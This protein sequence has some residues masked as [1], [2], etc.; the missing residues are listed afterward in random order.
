MAQEELLVE[1][2]ADVSEAVDGFDEVTE[3]AEGTEE[4]FFDLDPA[5]AAASGGILAVGAASQEVLDQ[6]A[7]WREGLGRTAETMG[8]NRD[9][10]EELASSISNVTFPMDDAVGTMD[11]LARQGVE[12]KDEMEEVALRMDQMA[13]ATGSSAESI[14]S[15]VAPTLKAL[16][17]D[18]T[19]VE[20]HMDT[21]TFV[22]RNTGLSIEG[23]GK[24]V[25]RLAP[26]LQKMGAG[27]DDVGAI[28]AA[29]E[30]KGITGRGALRELNQA[31]RNAEGDFGKMK[32]E[33]G[34]TNEEVATQRDRLEDAEGVTVSHADAAN[35]ALTAQDQLG[36]ALDEV[37]LAAGS[38]MG[39]VSA[40]APAMEAMGSA[41]L[42]MS[43]VNFSAVVPGLLAAT[44]AALPWILA[45]GAIV[46]LGVLLFKKWDTVTS[47]LQTAWT[48]TVDLFT[49]L[50]GDLVRVL[51]DA[52]QDVKEA[53]SRVWAKVKG[54][55]KDNIAG[56]VAFLVG[57][58]I[59]F[60]VVKNWGK[61]R[62]AAG[63]A[64]ASIRDLI[65]GPV[66]TFTG[67]VTG[68]SN[69]VKGTLVAA[70]AF[71]KDLTREAWRGIRNFIVNPVTDA[72]DS[73][74]GILGSVQ[75][76]LGQVWDAI[77]EKTGE[78]WAGVKANILDPLKELASDVFGF[79]QDIV[80][81]F[82][83]GLK[84]KWDSFTGW[85]EDK[86]GAVI[87][88]VTD[89]FEF[90]SPSRVFE[91]FGG[92]VV[93]GFQEGAADFPEA[94]PTGAVERALTRP[95]GGP[96]SSSKRGGGGDTFLIEEVTLQDVRDPDD[97]LRRL[98]KR[99]RESSNRRFRKDGTP[100]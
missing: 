82:W 79:G 43:T 5:G 7:D 34:L 38:A 50:T 89:I 12:T 85:I 13:D 96:T 94:V 83:D 73:V 45:I 31:A 61:I 3:S 65:M 51:G 36:Q 19:D 90:G 22:A 81:G 37:K 53:T 56:I 23:F 59:L 69:K 4:A 11:V 66:A 80:Q 76:K 26:D 48:A 16:G 39:P 30:E 93:E 6:T 21:F 88:T 62:A 75:S 78:V 77:L 27:V 35:E 20:E 100:L 92:W 14:A 28:M 97:L 67:F 60:V 29:L 47:F 91:Q 86:F 87:G 84:D 58:P 42:F 49:D 32:E 55:V 1:V 95:R 8:L 33:L 9:E 25:E 74:F 41:G 54:F 2:G 52:W 99:V 17:E 98:E 46:A 68:A 70:W 40:A 10:A 15:T 64:W 24:N 71:L 57:G 18:V 63:S 72:K 44:A